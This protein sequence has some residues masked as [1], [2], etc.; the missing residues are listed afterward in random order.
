MPALHFFKGTPGMTTQPL[1]LLRGLLGRG[2]PQLPRLELRGA[3]HPGATEISDAGC[4]DEL[5]RLVAG[6]PPLPQRLALPCGEVAIDYTH[7]PGRVSGKIALVTGAAQGFGLE[8]AEALH[9]QG[10]YVVL[11]DLNFDG[12][13]VAAGRLNAGAG[14]P[15]ALAVRV[16]VTDPASVRD[17]IRATVE[18]FGGLDL[19]VSNA[20]VLKAESLKTQS[21]KDFDFVTDINYK[22]FFVCTQAA[23]P[24]MA[25]QHLAAPGRWTDIIQINS[26]SG[27]QGSNKNAAYAGSKFG[28]IGLVQSFAYE[29]VQDAVKVNAICPGNFFDGPLWSHPENGLFAQYLRTGKVPGAQTIADVKAFYEA[30]VPMKRGCTTPDVMHAIYYLVDQCYETGQALPVAGGQVMLK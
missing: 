5:T 9:A 22:G 30:K 26:K 19:L 15:S 21:I 2:L 12:A 11:A 10:A 4:L 8:I 17:A 25:R 24:V 23:A 7:R 29:L 1:P 27:L 14:S 16:N 28:G 20:G 3:K 6:L 13:T 18:T